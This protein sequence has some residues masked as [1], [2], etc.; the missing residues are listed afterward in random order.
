M[1]NIKD[2]ILIFILA[3]LLLGGTLLNKHIIESKDKLIESQSETISKQDEH[4]KLLEKQIK[5]ISDDT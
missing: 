1:S 5:E 4:I 2:E 3:T